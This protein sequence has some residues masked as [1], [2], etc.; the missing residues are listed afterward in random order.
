MNQG[1]INSG[2]GAVDEVGCDDN[3]TFL[4]AVCADQQLFT[5]GVRAMVSERRKGQFEN[6]APLKILGHLRIPYETPMLIFTICFAITLISLTSVTVKLSLLALLKS[7]Q[8]GL[9]SLQM[10]SLS[11]RRTSH[12]EVNRKM[13]ITDGNRR[14]G[15]RI[16]VEKGSPTDVKLNPTSEVHSKENA[17]ISAARARFHDV[18][19]SLVE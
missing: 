8:A 2:F 19:R 15:V 4:P 18:H 16:E 10:K 13:S 17:L 14:M 12:S 11:K 3:K 5:R 7:P 9:R 6:F 1:W